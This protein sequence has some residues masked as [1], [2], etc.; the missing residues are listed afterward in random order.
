[1]D[2][3]LSN[4]WIVWLI[5]GIIALIA[6]LL[7]AALV[8]VWFVP[9]ALITALLSLVVKDFVWQLVI[10][11]VLSILFMFVLRRLYIKYIKKPKDAVKKEN[12]LIGSCAKTVSTVTSHGGEVL[13][14][15]VY[16]RAVS[17]NG[18]TIPENENVTVTDIKSTTL[19]VKKEI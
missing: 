1:M 2:F 8:S 11:S 10:F 12:S 18:E 7:T 4:L 16:W 5:I 13:S 3:I 9:A 17:A 19:I 14:G 15:D 6:E